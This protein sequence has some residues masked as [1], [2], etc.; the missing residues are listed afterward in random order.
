MAKADGWC[1]RFD[2]PIV[3][4]DGKKLVTLRDAVQ[5]LAK[6]V[7][8]AEQSHEAVLVAAD[9]LTRSAEQGYPMVF[10]RMATLQAIHRND[11]RV[12]NPDR[13]DHHWGKRKLKRDQ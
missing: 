8:K 13:K 11:E 7:P 10:A 2:D 5:Y 1:R 9:H 12:F 4:P 3:L 6:T